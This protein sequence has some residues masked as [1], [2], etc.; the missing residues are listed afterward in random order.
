MLIILCWMLK[1]CCGGEDEESGSLG[2]KC[3]A[4]ESWW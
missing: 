1:I 3:Y 4:F 2:E